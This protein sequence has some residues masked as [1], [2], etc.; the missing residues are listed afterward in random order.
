MQTPGLTNTV[1]DVIRSHGSVRNYRPDPLP[2]ETVEI[3]VA[4]AQRAS[5]SSNLQLWTAV[6][7]T[8][9]S[10]RAE[11]SEL[12]GGQAHIREAPVFIAWC[13][14]LQRMDRACEL[15]GYQQAAQ[16]VENFL[17]AAV[18][19]AIAAQTAAIAAESLGLGMCYIGA[20]R[21]N[22]AGVIKLLKLPR[23]VFPITGMTLGWP[24]AQPPIRPRLPLAGVLHWE[25]YDRAGE[26]ASLLAYDRAMI[27][28]GI[29]AGRQVPVPGQTG[30]M[31]EYGWLEHSA[32][33]VSQ[34]TRIGLRGVLAE[35]GFGLE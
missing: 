10:R 19:C 30:E 4:A 21:N 7:V 14:D 13:A 9:A 2:A 34:P 17:V 28:T 1:I 20:I 27:E 29:Y 15:R 18:D 12:C 3:V 5:T 11:M 35:Q 22:P 6:A 26:D 32:R 31:E 33:R 8:D 23:L 16:Y 24:A 25:T